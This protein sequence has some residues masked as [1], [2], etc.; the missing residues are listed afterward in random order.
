MQDL[1][2][3][4]LTFLLG[5]ATGAAGQYFADKYT[6]KRRRKEE[7]KL[8]KKVFKKVNNI[9]PEL[10]QEMRSDFKDPESNSVREIVILPNKRVSFNSDRPRF[11]YYEN[12]HE[13]LMGK[14]ATLENHGYLYDV[15]IG[16]APIYRIT[17]EFWEM[18]SNS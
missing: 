3:Y 9:M 11:R 5:V 17:E 15:T 4:G 7:A 2:N 6:D 10:I 16:S 13:N 18:I 1:I 12:E 8:S 14:I